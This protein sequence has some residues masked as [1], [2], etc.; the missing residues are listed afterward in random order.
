[1]TLLG[2]LALN[3]DGDKLPSHETRNVGSFV[4]SLVC[5]DDDSFVTSFFLLGSD[6]NTFENSSVATIMLSSLVSSSANSE[7]MCIV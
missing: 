7:R 6:N 5:T 1:M 4:A 2:L 3:N